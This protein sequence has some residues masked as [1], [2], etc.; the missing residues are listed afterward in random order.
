MQSS[1][2]SKHE[3]VKLLNETLGTVKKIEQQFTVLQML[4]SQLSKSNETSSVYVKIS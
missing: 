1:Y 4:R 3:M 2:V